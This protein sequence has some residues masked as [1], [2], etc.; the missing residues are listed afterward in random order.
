MM[1]TERERVE[2]GEK[3]G[4]VYFAQVGS[5]GSIKIGWS[6][7]PA[8]RIAKMQTGLPSPLRLLGVIPGSKAAEREA[9]ILFA[10]G[11]KRGEWF[12]RRI[13]IDGV[14]Q[15]IMEKGFLTPKAPRS[16]RIPAKNAANGFFLVIP[17]R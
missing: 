4:W 3:L 5:G 9:H 11:R 7:N 13:V 16:R 14:M 2:L 10:H 15:L 6:K 8:A 1:M 17:S 12:E